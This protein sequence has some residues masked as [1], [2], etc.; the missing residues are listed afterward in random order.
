RIEVGYGLEGTLTDAM[1]NDIIRNT[2]VP[3]FKQG[4]Y[5]G[6]ISDGVDRILAVLGGQVQEVQHQRRKDGSSTI[7][8]VIFLAFILLRV[9]M[10]GMRPGR[11]SGW[12][13]LWALTNMGGGWRGG[14]GGFG[15]GGGGFSGGGGS[16]GGGGA[17][18]S[19]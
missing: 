16:F 7:F 12:W 17:S 2:I 3:K 14:G 9:I 8:L 11:M 6:G 10:A 19:W 13:W 4:D 18:G 15:G 1:S 5:G